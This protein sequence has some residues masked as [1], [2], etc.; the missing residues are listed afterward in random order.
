MRSWY[1]SRP[2]PSLCAVVVLTRGRKCRLTLVV[3]VSFGRHELEFSYADPPM[4]IGRS[5]GCLYAQRES[6]REPRPGR[7]HSMT[8]SPVNSVHRGPLQWWNDAAARSP[9]AEVSTDS[10]GRSRPGR[11]T[12]ATRVEEADSV[13][14]G[15]IA[16]LRYMLVTRVQESLESQNREKTALDLSHGPAALPDNT[17]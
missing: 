7:R 3:V 15:L 14:Y 8:I 17:R 10:G 11:P 16:Y 4:D 5:S 13:R 1:A 6:I 2:T 12:P 9:H